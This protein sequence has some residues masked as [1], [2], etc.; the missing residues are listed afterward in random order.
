MSKG[1]NSKNGLPLPRLQLR[2]LPSTIKQNYQWECHYELVIPLHQ[3]DIRREIYGKRGGMKKG[4]KECV[5]PMKP[6]SL[7][8]GGEPCK[9]HDGSR[10]CD[11]PYRDG[12]HAKWDSAV[13]GGI[14][15]CCIAPDGM[16]FI[17]EK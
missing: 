2:W 14:P 5:I 12:A 13:L 9:N 7:R 17:V 6:P 4:P 16:T 10:Y 15:V 3:Y 11:T 1:L 8:D